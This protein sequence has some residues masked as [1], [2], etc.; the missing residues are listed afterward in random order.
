MKRK[1]SD[2]KTIIGLCNENNK[3]RTTLSIAAGLFEIIIEVLSFM[4]SI[5]FHIMLYFSHLRHSEFI[6][7]FPHNDQ[8]EV[9]HKL[10]VKTYK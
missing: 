4:A 9:R 8:Y 7:Y 10:D 6:M 2:C 1:H 5:I 3:E